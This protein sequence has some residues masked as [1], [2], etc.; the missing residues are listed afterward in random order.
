M[1]LSHRLYTATLIGLSGAA[2]MAAMGLGRGD[3]VMV[4]IAGVGAFVAGLPVAGLFGHHGQ[5]GVLGAVAGAVMATALGAM[6]AGFALAL[7]SG[8][9]GAML[10]GPI[11]VATAILTQ[12]IVALSWVGSMAG[13]HFLTLLARQEAV[14]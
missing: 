4:V 11:A 13:V 9:I 5:D 1:I 14:Y 8:F 12:P 2:T 3:T 7:A 6:L 10:L